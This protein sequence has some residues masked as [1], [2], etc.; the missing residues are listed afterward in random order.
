MCVCVCVCVCMEESGPLFGGPIYP[1]WDAVYSPNLRSHS[2]HCFHKSVFDGGFWAGQ[3]HVE[4][5]FHQ[6]EAA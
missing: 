1:V 6:T 3:E 2:Q 4:F 5:D